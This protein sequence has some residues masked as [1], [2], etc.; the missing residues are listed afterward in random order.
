MKDGTRRGRP[1]RAEADIERERARIAD[2]ASALFQHEGVEAIS[3]RRLAKEADVTPKTLYAYFAAKRDILQ[4][5]WAAFFVELFDEIGQIA[6]STQTPET[7]LRPACLCYLSYWIDQ[8]D[9]YRMV[10]MSDGV[11][12]SD[13]SVF[14]E[15]S[16][17]VARY[18]VFDQLLTETHGAEAPTATPLNALI[19]ALNGIVHNKVTISNYDWGTADALLDVLLPGIVGS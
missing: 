12:Q 1:P 11:T 10:F 6:A 9:R 3:M 7:R 2:I 14:V 19:C 4:H 8:P 18:A 13:V 5:I 17:I 16:P 15:S